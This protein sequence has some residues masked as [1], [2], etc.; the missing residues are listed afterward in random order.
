MVWYCHLFENFPQ[1]VVIYT[2]KGFDIVNK[3]EMDVHIIIHLSKLIDCITPS[4]DLNVNSGLRTIMT[5]QCQFMDY[6]KCQG[7]V[8]REGCACMQEQGRYMGPCTV[9]S[10]LLRT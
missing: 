8:S 6:N 7:V 1:F 5:C 9:H 2:A 3:A 10:I 4:V